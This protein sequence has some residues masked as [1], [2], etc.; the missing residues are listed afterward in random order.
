MDI[1]HRLLSR[2]WISVPDAFVGTSSVVR[3]SS[4][5]SLSGS[6]CRLRSFLPLRARGEQ[7]Q[8]HRVA[9]ALEL[10]NR[11]VASLLLYAFDNRFRDLGAALGDCR[12]VFPP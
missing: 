6:L 9:L 10:F 4:P 3:Q 11:A 2:I 1:D 12:E 8:K 5:N 7:L